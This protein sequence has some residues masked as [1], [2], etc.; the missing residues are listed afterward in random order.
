MIKLHNRTSGRDKSE[1]GGELHIKLEASGNL[2]S[3]PWGG[4]N[5]DEETGKAR[6]LQGGSGDSHSHTAWKVANADA[7]GN[8]ERVRKALSN[9]VPGTSHMEWKMAH[10]DA[11]GGSARVQQALRAE[12]RQADAVVRD[13]APE[14]PLTLKICVLRASELPRQDDTSS[15][16]YVKLTCGKQHFKTKVKRRD[17]N[18][19]WN[20]TFELRF[21]SLEELRHED[22]SIEVKD[23]DR[24]GKN[25][26]MCTAVAKDLH[27]GLGEERM[28]KLHNRTSG[29]DKS[30]PGGE[31]HIK[32]EASGPTT[33]ALSRADGLTTDFGETNGS[34][35]RS[36]DV[37]DAAY[38]P[39]DRR[40]TPRE[41]D[42][43]ICGETASPS[44]RRRDRRIADLR[45]ARDEALRL[46]KKHKEWKTAHG[47]QSTANSDSSRST[48]PPS[49][50]QSK[51]QHHQIHIPNRDKCL[52]EGTRRPNPPDENSRVS[53]IH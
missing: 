6:E 49:L 35:A 28:I 8:T 45:N 1:P 21:E 9:G 53:A 22:I 52:E 33:A 25:D 31:L 27:V 51:H 13:A 39:G 10:A 30:E 40:P 17:L 11:T 4:R 29:R 36:R 46:E 42:H 12:P 15:D 50:H 43:V 47:E 16:P 26:L 14:G 41:R 18:P 5:G 37:V 19:Q 2:A 34:P 38:S 32:L 23:W 48:V 44:E 24:F 7:T 3:A 20:E